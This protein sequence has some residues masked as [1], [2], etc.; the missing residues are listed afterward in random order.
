MEIKDR[1]SYGYANFNRL[2]KDYE[3]MKTKEELK[4]ELDTYQEQRDTVEAS[5]EHQMYG[6]Q[7]QYYD[8]FID[9]L[10][11]VLNDHDFKPMV[12]EQY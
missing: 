4:A 1:M 6:D 11:W 7:T 3:N 2:V 10:Y 8:G 9:A 5:N 12:F